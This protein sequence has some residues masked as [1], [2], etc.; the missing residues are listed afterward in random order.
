M[1]MIDTPERDLQFERLDSAYILAQARWNDHVD[2]CSVCDRSVFACQTGLGLSDSANAAWNAARR[3]WL[4][5]TEE[6]RSWYA[7]LMRR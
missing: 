6:Q 5:L 3:A 1:L 4:G 7:D 2:H